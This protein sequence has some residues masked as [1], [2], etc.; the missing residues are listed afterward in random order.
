MSQALQRQP[1]RLI[2]VGGGE[3]GAAELQ[4]GDEA[5]KEYAALVYRQAG[6]G[7]PDRPKLRIRQSQHAAIVLRSDVNF[8]TDQGGGGSGEPSRLHTGLFGL[9]RRTRTFQ[10]CRAMSAFGGKADIDR[11]YRDVCF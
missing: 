4:L 10:L 11:T 8:L 9:D 5:P 1:H 3:V 7:R 6:G 2:K